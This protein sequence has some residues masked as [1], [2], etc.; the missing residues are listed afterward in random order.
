MIKHGKKKKTPCGHI[1]DDHEKDWSQEEKS[2]YPQGRTEEIQ[3]AYFAQKE[4]VGVAFRESLLGSPDPSEG[5][6]V[7][8]YFSK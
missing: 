3:S 8:V 6:V 4:E 1:L 7:L 5:R 2:A